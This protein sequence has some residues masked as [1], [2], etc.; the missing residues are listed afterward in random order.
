MNDNTTVVSP[1]KIRFAAMDLLTGREISR[2]ELAKKL[3]KRFDKD[4]A[5]GE[6]LDQLQLEGLQCDQRFAEAF[7]RSR[8]HRGQGLTR[9]RGALREKGIGPELCASALEKAEIDWFA[10]AREVA[11]R[12]FGRQP[13]VNPK[14]KAQRTRFLI[15]RGFNIDQIKHAIREQYLDEFQD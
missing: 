14:E 12:K 13:A 8:R 9:I 15:Y 7:V 10:L 1:A 11:D 3:N 4:S 2:A 6:V 5:I